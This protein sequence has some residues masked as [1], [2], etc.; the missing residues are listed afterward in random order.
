MSQPQVVNSPGSPTIDYSWFI[1]VGPFFDRF[2]SAKMSVLASTNPTVIAL[3]K[4]VQSRK[5][6]DLKRT[7][8]GQAIDL[9]ISAPIAGVDATLKSAILNTPVNQLEQLALVR[10]YFS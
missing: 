9:I 7:D 1:D 6:V 2:G 5:W 4:D 10:A 8:V 3:V